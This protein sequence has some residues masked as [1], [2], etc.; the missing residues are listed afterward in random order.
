MIGKFIKPKNLGKLA[1]SWGIW[2][3]LRFNLKIIPLV[4]YFG[5]S[6]YSEFFLSSYYYYFFSFKNKKIY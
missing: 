4:H 6:F 1:N 2:G 3:F 5:I